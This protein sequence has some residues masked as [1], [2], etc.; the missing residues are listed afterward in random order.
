MGTVVN[1]NSQVYYSGTYWNDFPPVQEYICENFTGDKG[2]SWIDDFRQRFA[3]KPFDH[4]L[5]LNCG[6]GWVEREF[7]DKNI[8]KQATG[9][10]YS[11]DL[12]SLAQKERGPR[13]IHYFQADVN[14][15][16]F[17]E[18]HFDL[19]VNV[20]A[21]HH[22]QFINRL[23]RILCHTLKPEGH[24]VN[25]DYV[26]PHRN[27]YSLLNWLLINLANRSLSPAVR[28]S[29]LIKP[30]LPT[31][32]YADPTEAIH[33]ELIF[34]TMSN[35]FDI[36]E[37]HPTGGGIAYPILTHNQKIKDV[38]AQVANQQISKLLRIDKKLSHL[39]IVPPFF[40]YFVAKPRKE[41]LLGKRTLAYH[42]NLENQRENWAGEHGGTYS[43]RE[44]FCAVI[45][46]RLFTWLNQ[47]SKKIK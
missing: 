11:L 38:P 33:S 44:F 8:I 34:K 2:K 23:C 19:I 41:V 20:A 5:F 27:Q 24:F 21:L 22:V 46:R 10:D 4:G 35:Y 31:M 28:K 26:G 39:K 32:L 3:E 15:V 6:N 47:S 25:F 7:I 30:H 12:L 37:R 14:Q 45:L 42:Q 1:P 13:P 18:D 36:V 17:K 40:S 16:I 43:I 9:F 29:P